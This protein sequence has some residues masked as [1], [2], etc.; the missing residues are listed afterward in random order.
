MPMDDAVQ[1]LVR[2]ESA[3]DHVRDGLAFDDIDM[4]PSPRDG[5]LVVVAVRHG[6]WACQMCAEQFV[7]DAAHPQRLVEFNCGGHGTRI[8][9]HSCCVE[10]AAKALQ[11]RGDRGEL[12]F[13][14][15]LRHR[16]R[17][18]LTRFTKPFRNLGGGRDAG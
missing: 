14:L 6:V 7:D 8:A 15:S 2:Q 9:I 5:A 11:K 12:I 17:R 16:M 1:L 3:Y 18:A 4:F 13:D 10:A